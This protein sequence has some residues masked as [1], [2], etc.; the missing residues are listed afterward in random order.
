MALNVGKN[1][2]YSLAPLSSYHLSEKTDGMSGVAVTKEGVPITE[3]CGNKQHRPL[4]RRVF[5]V[6]LEREWN[7][8]SCLTSQW[9]SEI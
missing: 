6:L 9:L 4:T 7:P 8:A 1:S 3:D 5:L 2:Q